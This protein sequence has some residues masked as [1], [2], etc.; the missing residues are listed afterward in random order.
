MSKIGRD[1][2]YCS[3]ISEINKFAVNFGYPQR[4]ESPF[5][6]VFKITS[7]S[8]GKVC[9]DKM[10]PGA[11]DVNNIFYEFP[12]K[13]FYVQIIDVFQEGILMENTINFLKIQLNVFSKDFKEFKQVSLFIQPRGNSN[14]NQSF[15]KLESIVNFL[16]R[17][18]NR[19]DDVNKI[20]FDK[21]GEYKEVG[22]PI[23]C[24]T[25][26]SFEFFSDCKSRVGRD[27]CFWEEAIIT[28]LPTNRYILQIF[29][30]FFNRKFLSY[31]L[32]DNHIVVKISEDYSWGGWHRRIKIEKD[33]LI[34]E[35][36]NNL[37]FYCGKNYSNEDHIFDIY[38]K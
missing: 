22:F 9:I 3:G 33:E 25:Q 1:F 36:Q 12:F 11:F 17:F 8:H 21:I 34:L 29:E 37:I 28:Y 13:V 4:L 19:F 18:I 14:S 31:I 26:L 10:I 20:D 35:I 2:I 7:E 24:I 5:K 23:Y 15:T 30:S 38:T 32:E 6:L 27:D 16:N